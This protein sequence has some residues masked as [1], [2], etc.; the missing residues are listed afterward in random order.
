MGPALPDWL[1]IIDQ[2]QV[3]FVDNGGGLQGVSGALPAHVMMGEAVQFG[4][5][6]REQLPQRSLISVAPIAEQL[7]DCLPRG[8]ERHD[9]VCLTP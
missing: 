1:R 6:E 7:G 9:G 5:H 8:S 3:N 4:L 2:P